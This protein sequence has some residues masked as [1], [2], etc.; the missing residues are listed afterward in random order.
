MSLPQFLSTEVTLDGLIQDYFHQD[1][2]MVILEYLSIYHD[3]VISLA[4]LKR[5]LNKQGKV[6]F[7]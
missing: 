1:M 3:T 7:I 6:I 2:H 4:T 5:R